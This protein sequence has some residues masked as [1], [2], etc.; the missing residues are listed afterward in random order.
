MYVDFI[1]DV[2]DIKQVESYVVKGI[3][4]N[5]K[6]VNPNKNKVQDIHSESITEEFYVEK[7]I[8]E[9]LLP[10]QEVIRKL[11]ALVTLK[12]IRIR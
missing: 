9:K 12:R 10:I 4:P 1:A 8:P 7:K 5:E 2:E 3:V 11:Q 6:L